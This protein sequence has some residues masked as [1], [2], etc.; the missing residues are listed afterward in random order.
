MSCKNLNNDFIITT[1]M[2]SY[3]PGKGNNEIKHSI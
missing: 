1:Q 2:F 3:G